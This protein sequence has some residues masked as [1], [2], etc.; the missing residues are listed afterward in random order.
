MPRLKSPPP[1]ARNSNEDE[2]DDDYGESFDEE[3]PAKAG[4]PPLEASASAKSLAPSASGKS[5]EGMDLE[6]FM[7]NASRKGGDENAQAAND[8]SLRPLEGVSPNKN[9]ADLALGLKLGYSELEEEGGIGG[10]DEDEGEG[11]GRVGASLSTSKEKPKKQT[12]FRLPDEGSSEEEIGGGGGGGGGVIPLASKGS[13][14]PGR[15]VG[16]VLKQGSVVQPGP[17]SGGDQQSKGPI[18]PAMY[19]Y[20]ASLLN[21]KGDEAVEEQLAAITDEDSARRVDALLNELIPGR[22]KA[23]HGPK[24]KAMAGSSVSQQQPPPQRKI[25]PSAQSVASSGGAG[26]GPHQYGLG[27]IGPRRSLSDADDLGA[28]GDIRYQQSLESQIAVLKKDMR[29]RDDR[30]SRLTEHSMMLSNHCDNLKAELAQMQQ[31]LRTAELDLDAKEQR[32]A[33]AARLRKKAMKKSARLAAEMENYDALTQTCERLQNREQALLEAVEALSTQN[34]DL[35]KKLKASMGRELDLRC[36]RSLA[37]VGVRP[38]HSQ[39]Q[40]LRSPLVPLTSLTPCPLPSY[41]RIQQQPKTVKAIAS[42]K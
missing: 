8:P 33:D 24:S 5:L 35:I 22:T 41:N 31:K 42:S 7:K 11:E 39:T 10:D 3:S 15:K 34:E 20:Y 13:K 37:A 32:A 25:K 19:A 6:T 38:N 2:D 28:E 1:A 12:M 16:G 4:Q 9:P 29:A 30:L 21:R 26:A 40:R 18:T 27:A 17:S 23:T 14:P 36:V